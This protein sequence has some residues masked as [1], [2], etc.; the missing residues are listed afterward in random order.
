M[1]VQYIVE[2]LQEINKQVPKTQQPVCGNMEDA[3][4][5]DHIASKQRNVELQ[6]SAS[7]VTGKE[8]SNRMKSGKYKI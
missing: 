1:K 6:N 5:R 3:E 7:G 4:H 2:Y 8:S